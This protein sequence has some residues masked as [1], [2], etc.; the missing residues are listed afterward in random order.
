M[1]KFIFITNSL[2]TREASKIEF[3]VPNDLTIFEFKNICIRMASAMGYHHNTIL[4]AFETTS[5]IEEID[6]EIF[7]IFNNLGNY[8]QSNTSI[9][10]GSFLYNSL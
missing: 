7:N 4:K 1:S 5:E 9:T 3:E 2:N 6:K 8:K 10:T